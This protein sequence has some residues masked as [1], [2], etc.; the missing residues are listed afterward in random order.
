VLSK[1]G[2]LSA[3]IFRRLEEADQLARKG[4]IEEAAQL[5]EQTLARDPDNLSSLLNLLYLARYLS[6]LDDQVDAF[7]E[8]ARRI[9]PQVALA[10]DYYGVVMVRQGK[11]DAASAALRKAIELQPNDAEPYK[12]LGEILERQNRPAEAIE[13][14]QHALELEPFD[15]PLQMKLWWTL[16]LNGR[17]R[18]TIAQLLPALLVDDSYTSMRMVLLGEAYRTTRDFGKSRQYLEQA[19]N[20]VRARVRRIYCR[21]LNRN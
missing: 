12:F 16:I 2:E 14:Y 1:V 13:H 9:N 4:K 8:R 5:N 3:G 21:R 20:R 11:P 18:E 7:Y 15:R 19:R 10:Y 6:R 17:G